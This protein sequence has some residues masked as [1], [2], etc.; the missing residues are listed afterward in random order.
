MDGNCILLSGLYSEKLTY[1]HHVSVFSQKENNPVPFD[2]CPDNEQLQ[3]YA[4]GN[5]SSETVE[6]LAEHLD[7]CIDCQRTMEVLDAA[8]DSP[9]ARIRR[10]GSHDMYQDESQYEEAINRAK[11][12]LIEAVDPE[13]NSEEPRELSVI[14][15]YQLLSKLGQGGMG[16][17]YRARQSKLKRI[18][19]LK[20]LPKHLL[21]NEQARARFAREMQA[22][23]L[24]S[25]PN[26]VQAHDAREINGIPILAME[27]VDGLDLSQ[28]VASVGPLPIADACE[29]IRQSALGLQAAHEIGLVHRDIK[30]SNIMLTRT[31]QVKILDLGLALL[32]APE[33]GGS[34][35]T[36]NRRRI[37][38]RPGIHAAPKVISL[39]H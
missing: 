5:V 31:G 25:H 4:E 2:K 14:G 38:T 30:P 27:Y 3:A 6:M 7:T 32:I 10:A 18:V 19:A 26:I 29:L 33:A 23:G 36:G 15:E 17:V 12:I 16:T 22:V 8:E 11:T 20:V 9:V 34:E 13:A 28:L 24:L 35:M 21:E 1:F 37:R 39:R